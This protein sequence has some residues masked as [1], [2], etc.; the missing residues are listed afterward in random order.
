MKR[1]ELLL[2]DVS[3]LALFSSTR[4]FNQS[5]PS[6]SHLQVASKYFDASSVDVAVV[7]LGKKFETVIHQLDILE[8]F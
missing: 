1:H 5:M 6:E 2:L 3:P 8:S 7:G 4:T